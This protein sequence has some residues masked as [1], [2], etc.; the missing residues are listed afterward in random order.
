MQTDKQRIA[1]IGP[2]SLGLYLA[3]RLSLAGHLVEVAGRRPQSDWQGVTAQGDEHWQATEVGHVTL[4]ELR[5]PYDQLIVAVKS[6]DVAGVLPRLAALGGPATEYSFLQNGVPWWWDGEAA[7]AAAGLWNE[8]VNAVIVHHAVERL[9]AGTIQVRRTARDR[10]ICGRPAGGEDAPLRSLVAGWL[11]AGVPAE[12][13]SDIRS[14]MWAKLMG[15]ATLNP[16]SAITGA[17]VGAMATMPETR[18]VLLAG[19]AEIARIAEAEGCAV[20]STPEARVARAAEVGP[21]RTSML[22]DRIAGRPLEL[23]ALLE[24]PIHIARR[25]G[26]AVPVLRTLLGCLRGSESAAQN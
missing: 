12:C 3:G 18:D 1:I 24:R 26:V 21:V 22:Q 2:G 20:L 11:A 25:H 14:E 23:E 7:L 16:L 9:S 6:Q 19:M 5:G 17:T 10:Y 13:S 8:Q 15:N 4:D